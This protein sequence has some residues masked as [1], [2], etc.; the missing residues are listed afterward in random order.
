MTTIAVDPIPVQRTIMLLQLS[1]SVISMMD[2]DFNVKREMHESICMQ[3]RFVYSMT[4]VDVT[5]LHPDVT[6]CIIMYELYQCILLIMSADDSY[7]SYRS[8]PARMNVNLKSQ[9]NITSAHTMPC[10]SFVDSSHSPKHNSRAFAFPL[11][12]QRVPTGLRCLGRWLHQ[13]Y[14]SLFP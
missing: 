2:C 5:S 10:S 7:L 14:R 3:I 1:L 11:D 6:M 13:L 9:I 12:H 8:N 4:N